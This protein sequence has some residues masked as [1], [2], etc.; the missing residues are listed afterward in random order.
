MVRIV[1]GLLMWLAMRG[2]LNDKVEEKY[3]FYHVPCSNTAL[4][5]IILENK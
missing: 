5:H 1:A 2:A 4:G 3:R